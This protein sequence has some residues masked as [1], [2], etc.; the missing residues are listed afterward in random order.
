MKADHTYDWHWWITDPS[1]D[2]KMAAQL[3]SGSQQAS[4]RAAEF[5]KGA[6]NPSM[7][8]GCPVLFYISVLAQPSE[9]EMRARA[10]RENTA[11]RLASVSKD[12]WMIYWRSSRVLWSAGNNLEVDLQHLPRFQEALVLMQHLHRSPLNQ[13]VSCSKQASLAGWMGTNNQ[14]FIADQTTIRMALKD[15][16]LRETGI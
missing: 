15:L 11:V 13:L 12:F 3:L 9:Q 16:C 5:S 2:A 10:V 8:F 1:N 4:K 6:V 14:R 7:R